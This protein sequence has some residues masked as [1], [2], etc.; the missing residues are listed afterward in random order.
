MSYLEPALPLLLLIGLVGLVQAWRHSAGG[1]RPWALTLSIVGVVLLSSTP[2]AWLFS[3]PLE[4]WYNDSPAP[5]EKA[6]AIVVLAGPVD[7]P[8][9]D[10]P[11]AL[12][13]ADTFPRVQHAA[14]LFKNWAARPI[15]MSG[16]GKDD[17]AN[18]KLLRHLLE[19]EG[20]P[21]DMIWIEARSRSIHENAVYGSEVLRQHGV[22]R[23][24]L[25]T[26]ASSMVRAAASFRKQ[27]I[28]VV[29]APFAFF[30]LNHN[31]EDILPEWQ[32]IKSAGLS[33]HELVGL[34]WYRL[35]GWI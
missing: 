16:G 31:V 2:A 13:G 10:R 25:V 20:I 22:T 21:A 3:R 27:G 9:P 34:V 23:I 26:D 5:A 18:S 4:M 33:A 17:E 1:R 11:Y 7:P 35:H 8:A 19:S 29:P 15:L 30:Q 28:T 12:A 24:A 14:W 6:D 32:A